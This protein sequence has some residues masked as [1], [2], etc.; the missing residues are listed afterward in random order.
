MQEAGAHLSL[1]RREGGGRVGARKGKEL[2]GGHGSEFVNFHSSRSL[3][4]R[5][6]PLCTTAQRAGAP[7]TGEWRSVEVEGS[8]HPLLPPP[9]SLG[10][11]PSSFHFSPPLPPPRFSSS[12]VLPP[13]AAAGGG[14]RSA[15]GPREQ[16]QRRP[17]ERGRGRRDLDQRLDRALPLSPA[18][19]RAPRLPGRALLSP[20]AHGA[21]SPSEA[22]QRG[23]PQL[24]LCPSLFPSRQ[25]HREAV[26]LLYPSRRISLCL[27]LETGEVEGGNSAAKQRPAKSARVQSVALTHPDC[28]S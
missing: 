10:L 1:P 15:A 26:R 24:Q 19:L 4:S 8:A 16:R 17:L 28:G 20:A 23:W 7:C 12:K 22:A 5:A 27:S 11:T 18:A 9:P 13:P 3:G 6:H 14:G 2:T 25:P 21:P